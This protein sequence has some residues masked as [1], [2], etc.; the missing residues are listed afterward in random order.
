MVCCLQVNVNFDCQPKPCTFSA[1]NCALGR[2][3]KTSMTGYP[4]TIKNPAQ[5]ASKNHLLM[6]WVHTKS[7]VKT[8]F[9][10]PSSSPRETNR[11]FP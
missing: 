8:A 2:A 1:M 10:H 5:I 9:A 4:A 3:I 6:Q 11:P 7:D